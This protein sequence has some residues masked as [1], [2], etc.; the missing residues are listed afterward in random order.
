[1]IA[2]AAKAFAAYYKTERDRSEKALADILDILC[3]AE[4]PDNQVQEVL[5]KLER[6]WSRSETAIDIKTPL[7]ED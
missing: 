4:K 5:G 6:H 3:S 1:M 7:G 2:D